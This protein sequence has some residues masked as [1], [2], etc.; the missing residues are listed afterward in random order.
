MRHSEK[1]VIGNSTMTFYI[2]STNALEHL[3]FHNYTGAF[4]A[5][6]DYC[7]R[8]DQAEIDAPF[9]LILVIRG[10]MHLEFEGHTYE[11]RKGEMLLFESHLPHCYY[12]D[13]DTQFRYVH[14]GGA[15]SRFLVSRICQN[16]QHHFTLKNLNDVETCLNLLIA[17]TE[18][19]I[20]N[21][22]QIS[23]QIYE[24][25]I[26][27]ITGKST[28]Q[29]NDTNHERISTAIALMKHNLG[30][31]IS[32]PDIADR[33][34]L[35]PSYFIRLFK[36]YTDQSPYEYLLSLRISQAKMLLYTTSDSVNAIAEQCGYPDS[37][38][39]I[40]LFK[41]YVGSTPLQF[42]K[43]HLKGVKGDGA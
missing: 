5:N 40:R 32:V 13:D 20:P 36:Q 25:L 24:L 4:Y 37:S 8:R 29:V 10:C 15:E 27:I 42:K 26:L 35:N 34:G 6:S 11:A 17:Y 23:F 3:Y 14:F 7:I 19:S 30:K 28:P 16:H 9:L 41:K 18:E 12:A 38:Y 43:Y 2:P 33:I 39:F 21:E 22:Y 1:G 31:E